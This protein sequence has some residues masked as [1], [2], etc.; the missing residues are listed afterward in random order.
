GPGCTSNGKFLQL[1]D[2]LTGAKLVDDKYPSPPTYN[3]Q[4]LN[5]L[6]Y[7]PTTTDPCGEISYSI[8]KL[9]SDNQFVTRVDYSINAKNNLYAR[10][11]IDGYQLPA[12]FFPTNILVTTQSGNIQRVQTFTLGESYTISPRT[13][14][15][16]HVTVSR[17][18]ND[19]GY[20]PND[21]NAAT[22]GVDLYQAVPNGLQLSVS[23]KFTIGGGT[24]SVSHFNDN[25]LTFSDDITMLR[26]KHQLV[27]GGEWVQNQL[28]IGNAYQSNGNFGF[29]GRYSANGPN[30]GSAGSEANLDF[31]MGTMSTFQQSKQQQNALRA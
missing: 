14:N 22:L 16:F 31:L 11:F 2:P 8:T 13:V 3:A 9:T 25:A 18:R 10:Y 4:S 19:R 12:F 17:R 7:M 5:L 6:K 24:N 15:T 26:G 21:I 20:A 23:N 1:Y 27:F 28:N 30:G 29:D